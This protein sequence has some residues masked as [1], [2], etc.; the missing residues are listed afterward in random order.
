MWMLR[1]LVLVLCWRLH[2]PVAGMR[3]SEKDSV[4]TNSAGH[5]PVQQSTRAKG[6]RLCYTDLGQ[7]VHV[8]IGSVSCGGVMFAP[9][10]RAMAQVQRSS[11]LSVCCL[12]RS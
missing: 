1:S 7:T 10:A 11:K 9:E 5:F 6:Q 8:L 12:F 3:E 2:S 4:R